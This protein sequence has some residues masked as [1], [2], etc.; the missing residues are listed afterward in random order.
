MRADGDITI[1]KHLQRLLPGKF[2]VLF[3]IALQRRTDIYQF[4]ANQTPFRYT[5]PEC[6]QVL[7]NSL[8]EYVIIRG[9]WMVDVPV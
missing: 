7:P 6:G 8:P 4:G 2:D 9:I 1:C 5:F 3:Y